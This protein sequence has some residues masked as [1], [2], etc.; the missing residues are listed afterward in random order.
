VVVEADR[1]QS[2]PVWKASPLVWILR[3]DVSDD[4]HIFPSDGTFQAM[5]DRSRHIEVHLDEL[6]GPCIRTIDIQDPNLKSK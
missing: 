3:T 2:V 6:N 5:E 4:R 1:G